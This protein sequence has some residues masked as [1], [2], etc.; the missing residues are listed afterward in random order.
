MPQRI[1]LKPGQTQ[2]YKKERMG[3]GFTVL[4]TA[5]NVTYTV[6]NFLV[7]N[8][9]RLNDNLSVLMKDSKLPALADGGSN[10]MA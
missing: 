6:D 4:H 2:T 9:D 7:K 10:A 5:A 3:G 8:R 1:E